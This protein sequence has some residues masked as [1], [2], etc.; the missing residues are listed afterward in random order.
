[1]PA[2]TRLRVVPGEEWDALVARLGGLDTY[3]RAAY[4]RASALLWPEGAE[5]VLLHHAHPGGEVALPLLLRSLPDG[6]GFD[7]TSAYGYGGPVASSTTGLEGFAEALDEWARANYVVTTFL[8][9][10]PLLGNARLV[11]STADLASMGPTVAWDVTTGRDLRAHMHPHHRRA[12]RRSE[13]AGV[14]VEVLLHPRDLDEFCDLYSAT[15]RRRD[16]QRFYFFPAAYWKALL[17][18][19]AQL[20][21]LVVEARLAGELVAALL[22]FAEG[23]WLHYHLGASSDAGR[24]TG[25]SNHCFLVGAEWAQARGMTRFHLGGG[26]GA[27]PQSPLMTFKQRFDPT[28]ELLPFSVAKLVHDRDRYLRLAGTD[29]TAGFFPPWRRAH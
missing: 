5:P 16:A 3:T 18:D 9:L 17:D 7:A 24:S 4:H 2:S 11:P 29:E 23:P 28:G 21:L 19:A 27:D 12:V 15:M 8:R 14:E 6:D 13:N 10:H 1:M 20:G 26:L 22:C 25:A